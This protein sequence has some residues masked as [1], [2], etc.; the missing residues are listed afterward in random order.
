MKI[1]SSIG[2]LDNCAYYSFCDNGWF[3]V[4]QQSESVTLNRWPIRDV[5]FVNIITSISLQSESENDKSTLLILLQTSGN[6]LR[7]FN[8]ESGTFQQCEM[9][10]EIAEVTIACPGEQRLILIV[11]ASGSVFILDLVEFHNTFHHR[12]P[13]QICFPHYPADKDVLNGCVDWLLAEEFDVQH[14]IKWLTSNSFVYMSTSYEGVEMVAV[15]VEGNL[16]TRY[17]FP[18]SRQL[19]RYSLR[20]CRFNY[21]STSSEVDVLEDDSIIDLAGMEYLLDFD[22]F[23]GLVYYLICDRDQRQVRLVRCNPLDSQHCELWNSGQRYFHMNLFSV[24]TDDCIVSYFDRLRMHI[25]PEGRV[26]EF[27]LDVHVTKFI[28][29]SPKKDKFFFL[30]NTGYRHE[31]CFINLIEKTAH[32][33]VYPRHCTHVLI[34]SNDVLLIETSHLSSSDSQSIVLDISKPIIFNTENGSMFL[35]LDLIIPEAGMRAGFEIKSSTG[36]SLFGIISYPHIF[37]TESK[38]P[39]LLFVYG[40]PRVQNCTDCHDAAYSVST[41]LFQRCGY[42]VVTLDCRGS[43]NRGYD[44]EN[45]IRFQVPSVQIE[46]HMSLLND[47]LFKLDYID[48]DNV[49]L[50]GWSF[51]GYLALK[52]A[53]STPSLFRRISVGAPLVL[54]KYYDCGYTE[55]Y[56]GSYSE[57]EYRQA[58]V[59][60]SPQFVEEFRNPIFD[61]PPRILIITGGKDHNVLSIHSYILKQLLEL[62]GVPHRFHLFLDEAHGI[63]KP[64][65]YNQYC[66]ILKDFFYYC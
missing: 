48:R 53:E 20:M 38:H 39:L 51:G 19:P 30:H 21:S 6:S 35:P 17:S 23:Q 27:D 52:M 4:Q 64:A 3:I 2:G 14:G 5:Q 13:V 56:L 61:D 22:C 10:D 47:H 63:Q 26:I 41:G 18:D 29:L 24:V 36:E 25:L 62:H 60:L 54:W 45:I 7:L 34:V 16:G 58:S 15:D 57:R 46:D 55:R 1:H 42:V 44:F 32:V 65:N 66:Q 11:S 9:R 43:G 33:S 28:G 31:L 12:Q 50:H 8:T 59:T 40:G 37:S 49:N